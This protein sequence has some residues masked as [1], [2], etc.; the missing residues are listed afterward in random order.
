MYLRGSGWIW[1][2]PADLGDSL[3]DEVDGVPD[4]P[5]EGDRVDRAVELGQAVQHQRLQPRD[6][7]ADPALHVLGHE[8]AWGEPG[9]GRGGADRQIR[10]LPGGIYTA[11]YMVFRGNK[12]KSF[13]ILESDK[14]QT[15][16]CLDRHRHLDQIFDSV[17]YQMFRSAPGSEAAPPRCTGCPLTPGSPWPRPPVA[18]PPC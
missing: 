9:K 6:T 17:L 16:Y 7:V 3:W 10:H 1:M 11:V 15:F 13:M 5:P 14:G 8:L 2:D 4:E 18:R 12:Q